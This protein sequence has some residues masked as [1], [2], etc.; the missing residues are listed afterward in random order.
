MTPIRTPNIDAKGKG[1]IKSSRLPCASPHWQ[2]QQKFVSF[3]P[4]GRT[5]GWSQ[6][7]KSHPTMHTEYT[8][9]YVQ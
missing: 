1:T 8:S 2:Q 4:P 9:I 3:Q 5:F 6:G 7:L